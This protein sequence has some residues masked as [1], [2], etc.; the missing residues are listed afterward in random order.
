LYEVR[1]NHAFREVPVLSYQ[2]FNLTLTH[3]SLEQE[4]QENLFP[5]DHVDVMVYKVINILDFNLTCWKP[6]RQ[7]ETRKQTKHFLSFLEKDK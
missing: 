3:I 2:I 5:P 4:T 1:K 7:N 6:Q